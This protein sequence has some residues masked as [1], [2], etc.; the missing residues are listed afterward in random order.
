MRF[1]GIL[2]ARIVGGSAF[3]A[4]GYARFSESPLIANDLPS[5]VIDRHGTFEV[6][7]DCIGAVLLPDE[8]APR[9]RVH[10]F[11]L[12]PRIPKVGRSVVIGFNVE[13]TGLPFAA[14]S[15]DP[16]GRC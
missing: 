1:Y 6:G 11:R 9:I 16:R 4:D 12:L 15:I 3:P 13:V 5:Q 14:G 2:S 8:C 10:R 7:H